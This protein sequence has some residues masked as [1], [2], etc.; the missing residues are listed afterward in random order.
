MKTAFLLLISVISLLNSAA[1][2]SN[3]EEET[4]AQNGMERPQDTQQVTITVNSI[5]F[6]ATLIDS[7]TTEAFK[8]LLPLTINMTELNAN[9]KYFDLPKSLPINA[10]NPRTIH[11]GDLMLYGSNT[12]VLFYKTFPTSYNYTKIGKI[13][14]PKGLA[15]ALGLANA[16]VKFELE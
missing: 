4:I 9:E 5:I 13:D 7:P 8:E 2:Q 15:N 10:S 16:T 12:L 11:N 14:N 3:I 6:K 1:C